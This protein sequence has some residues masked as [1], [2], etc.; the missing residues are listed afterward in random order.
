MSVLS[1]FARHR[2][3]P[4]LLRRLSQVL[5]RAA[6]PFRG[7]ESACSDVRLVNRF[8]TASPVLDSST[9]SL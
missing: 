3:K 7:S 5:G 8:R 4:M 9:F 1:F 6:K 2:P